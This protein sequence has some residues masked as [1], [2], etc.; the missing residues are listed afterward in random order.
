MKIK[1]LSMTMALFLGCAHAFYAN[2][3]EFAKSFTGANAEKMCSEGGASNTS[4]RSFSGKYCIGT[5]VC[6]LLKDHCFP[7]GQDPYKATQSQ[8]YKK[9]KETMGDDFFGENNSRQ[10]VYSK[11]P[12]NKTSSQAF[13][14]KRPPIAVPE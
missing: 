3:E 10:A 9:C 5:D 13:Y 11:R 1:I 8:C 2:A 6:T 12:V 14:S 7:G 4:L